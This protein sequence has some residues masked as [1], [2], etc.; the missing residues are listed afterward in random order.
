MD[1]D[2]I[3]QDT[4]A[5]IRPQWKIVAGF[6]EAGRLFANAVTENYKTDEQEKVVEAEEA[7]DDE[8]SEEGEDIAMPEM[9]ERQSSS[10]E[11]E[12][13]VSFGRPFVIYY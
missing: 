9:D 12:I 2:F 8:S 10:E 3:V 11:V 4:Y 5:I 13:D 6:D 1:V 7:E